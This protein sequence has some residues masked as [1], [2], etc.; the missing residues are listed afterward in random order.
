MSARHRCW[1]RAAVDLLDEALAVFGVERDGAGR[2]AG[3]WLE[4]HNPAAVEVLGGGSGELRGRELGELGPEGVRDELRTVVVEAADRCG[5]VRRRLRSR[6][7][8]RRWWEVAVHSLRGER[9]TVLIRDVT[10]TVRGEEL[11]EAAQEDAAGV[12]ATL[13][14]VLDATSDRFAVYDVELDDELTPV[15][16]RLVLMNAAGAG[17]LGAVEDLIGQDL[18]ELYP[19]AVDSG[20]WGAVC[21]AV[22]AQ[23]SST[24]RLHEYDSTGHW[25]SSWDN[26][27]APV[28]TD[29]VVVTWRDVTE[30]ERRQRQSAV[31]HDG[32]RYA[33]GHDPLTGLANRTL[34]EE[35]LDEALWVADRDERVA[36]VFGDLDGFEEINDNLGHSTG[37]D[38][39]RV[40]ATRLTRA[41]RG[42]DTVGRVGGD[43]FVLLVRRLPPDW[44]QEAFIRRVRTAVEEP[45]LLPGHVV[46]PR[47]SLGMA[48]TPPE[49]R[50]V[51]QLMRLADE[52][53]YD[54]KMARRAGCGR[55]RPPV[56]LP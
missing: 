44:D 55:D 25:R 19:R 45:L 1:S 13:R 28:A 37:D 40:V 32:A 7:P 16:L 48:V 10:G 15:G 41:V 31:A 24:Y 18:R 43:E 34:V 46:G 47:L 39:L 30:E 33:A 14:A 52:R 17:P 8:G 3:L 9:V 4:A 56:G 36:V 12:R 42:S 54:D 11:L 26:T 53:M 49:Q 2:V 23:T 6:R 21:G 50:D 5:T 20:L 35:H 22:V 51:D 29:Q 27:I 38:V